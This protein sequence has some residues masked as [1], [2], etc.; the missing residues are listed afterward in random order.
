MAKRSETRW[1]CQDI[2]DQDGTHYDNLNRGDEWLAGFGD[3]STLCRRVAR[4]LNADDAA[5]RKKGERRG[6]G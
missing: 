1:W 3:N 5:R 4:L 2:V 6:N